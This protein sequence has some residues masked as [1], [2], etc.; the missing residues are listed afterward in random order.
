MA[1]VAERQAFQ[2]SF[3]AV[4]P[5]NQEVEHLFLEYQVL[6]QSVEPMDH[7]FLVGPLQWLPVRPLHERVPEV[8]AVLR[9]LEHL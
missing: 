4:D 5:L 6:Q 7:L 3:Q 9:P 8:Q 2:A 1:F